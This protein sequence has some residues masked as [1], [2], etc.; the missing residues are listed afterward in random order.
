MLTR[1][2]CV[3][4]H[5]SV[6]VTAVCQ[7]EEIYPPFYWFIFHVL[8]LVWKE[9]SFHSQ[10]F[11]GEQ[12]SLSY[13]HVLRCAYVRVLRCAYVCSGVPFCFSFSALVLIWIAH[14]QVP[15]WRHIE[16]IGDR[17]EAWCLKH[18]ILWCWQLYQWSI[19]HQSQKPVELFHIVPRVTFLSCVQS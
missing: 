9:W 4:V 8:Y 11:P 10:V 19:Q 16:H 3:A 1:E 6:P 12:R 17:S 5:N 7:D 13:L 14:V 18:V 2:H 15:H